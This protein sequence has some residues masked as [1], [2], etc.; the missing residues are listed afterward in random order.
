MLRAAAKLRASRN[1]WLTAGG[2]LGLFMTFLLA[3][4]VLAD[5]FGWLADGRVLDIAAPLRHPASALAIGMLVSVIAQSSSVATSLLVSAV[6]SGAVGL[7]A[8]VYAVIG[9]N[10]GT[11]ITAT[12]V[13]FRFAGSRLEFERALRGALLYTV[14]KGTTAGLAVAAERWCGALSRAAAAASS[15]FV[16]DGSGGASST[17]GAASPFFHALVGYLEI[18]LDLS[19]AAAAAFIFAGAFALL[20]SALLGLMALLRTRLAGPIERSLGSALSRNDG[21]AFAVGVAVTVILQTSTL[22]TSLM[23]PLFAAGV[24]VGTRGFGLLAGA[25]VGTTLKLVVAAATTNSA[26]MSLALAHLLLNCGGALI[27]FAP[28]PCRG[29][30]P[31]VAA[32]LAAAGARSV[33]LTA[34][35]AAVLYLVLPLT[36]LFVR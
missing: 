16:D 3:V 33:A 1:P 6:A 20:V 18:D 14:F 22:S 7:E 9:A 13:S 17:R 26:G 15:R 2:A 28:P 32:R 36:A 8:A 19:R 30:L 23:I 5:T 31:W 12:L 4:G 27:L 24:L 10:V 11:T 21:V 25:A 35:G 29:A 34:A